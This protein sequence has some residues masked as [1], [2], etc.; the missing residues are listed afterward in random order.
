MSGQPAE[1]VP[2]LV[3]ELLK[4]GLVWLVLAD[5]SAL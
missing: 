3:P 1:L 4:L 2:L 5:S